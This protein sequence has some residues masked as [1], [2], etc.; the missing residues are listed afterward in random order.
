MRTMSTG[1][2]EAFGTVPEDEDGSETR[3]MRRRLRGRARHLYGEARHVAEDAAHTVS[4][5]ISDQ[6]VAAVL[7]AAALG[8]VLGM[9]AFRREDDDMRWSARRRAL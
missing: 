6:P 2:R 4:R 7:I 5:R 8:F 1:A 9:V 3:G